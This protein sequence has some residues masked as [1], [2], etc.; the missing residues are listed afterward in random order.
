MPSPNAQVRD[1]WNTHIHDLEV[2]RHAP[3]TPEFFAD[4]DTYHF[5]KLHHLLRLIDFSAWAARDVL[6]IGCGASVEIMRFARAGA[7]VTGLDI[8]ERAIALTRANAAQQ[9]VPA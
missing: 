4:L 7:R 3:G 8:A 1:Y 6:D 2:S 9:R 5:D